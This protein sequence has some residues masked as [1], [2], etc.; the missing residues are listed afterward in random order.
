MP[1]FHSHQLRCDPA[2]FPA[3][4]A[5][6]NNNNKSS[7]QRECETPNFC[8]RSWRQASDKREGD[9]IR[10]RCEAVEY[11][12]FSASE[13]HHKHHRV[14]PHLRGSF[15]TTADYTSLCSAFRGLLGILPLLT[16]TPVSITRNLFCVTVK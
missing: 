1:C 14:T 3:N 7:E 10:R 8:H 2:N 5:E 9:S 6:H 15:R 11:R 4:G 13:P 12:A 16:A